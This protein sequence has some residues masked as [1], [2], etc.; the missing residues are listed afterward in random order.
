MKAVPAVTGIRSATGSKS[1][2]FPKETRLPVPS[3]TDR[4]LDIDPAPDEF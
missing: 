1:G 3:S 2:G 4:L